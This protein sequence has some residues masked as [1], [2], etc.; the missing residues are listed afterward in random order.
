M[1]I[2]ISHV[3]HN[4]IWMSHVTDINASSHTYQERVGERERQREREKECVC[5][6]VCV[7]VMRTSGETHRCVCVCVCM[8]CDWVLSYQKRHTH[9]YCTQR[10]SFFFLKC[11]LSHTP[12]ESG[13]RPRGPGQLWYWVTGSWFFVNSASWVCVCVYGCVCLYVVCVCIVVCVL[14]ACVCV[15]VCV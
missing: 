6:C 15:C 8:W 1:L 5:V 9:I 14:C 2:W 11:V 3:T 10:I 4:I 7:C 13:T 12:G